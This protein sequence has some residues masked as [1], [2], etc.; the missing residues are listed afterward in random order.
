MRIAV[1]VHINIVFNGEKIVTL[2][3][4]GRNLPLAKHT[5]HCGAKTQFI[6]EE[7]IVF[8]E[9]IHND[10]YWHCENGVYKERG[11][12][13]EKANILSDCFARVRQSHFVNLNHIQSI[14]PY[15][16]TVSSQ[17]TITIPKSR[18]K[19]IK[20]TVESWNRVNN[21]IDRGPL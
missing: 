14:E 11:T 20:D 5:I 21:A 3:L 15:K 18:Y 4:T 13:S 12:I 9:S 7:G 8:I 6:S 19:E 1:R 10:V 2:H 16:I 17:E